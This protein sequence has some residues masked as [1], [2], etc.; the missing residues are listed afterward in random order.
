MLILFTQSDKWRIIAA[1]SNGSDKLLS[2]NDCVSIVIVSVS[3][4]CLIG[5]SKYAITSLWFR[6]SHI[7]IFNFSWVGFVHKIC[8]TCSNCGF[9]WASSVRVFVSLASTLIRQNGFGS[10]RVFFDR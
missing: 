6:A 10:R 3:Y 5:N 1:L 2:G 9:V 8:D 4:I 7:S